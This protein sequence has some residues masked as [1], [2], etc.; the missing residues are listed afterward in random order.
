VS[1]W[2]PIFG[3]ID[4][5]DITT[6]AFLAWLLVRYLRRTRARAA[7]VGLVLLGTI[8]AAARGLDLRLTASLLQGFFAVAVL[9]LVVVFQEDIRRLFEQ[10]GSWRQALKEPAKQS[11]DDDLLVR[12][13]SR[14]AQQHVGALIVLP[15]REPLTRHV[16]GGVPLHGRIS[17]PLLLSI[18]DASSPG[19]DGAVIVRD[20]QVERFSVHLP[21]S[22]NHAALGP[23]GTR[24]AAALGLAERCDALCIVV[25][26]ERGSVSVARDGTLRTLRRPEDLAGELRIDEPDAAPSRPWWRTALAAEAAV[27]VVGALALWMIVVPGSDLIEASV[28]AQ[29]E[30]SN[31]PA[32]YELE[33][34]DPPQVDVL[35]RGLRRDVALAQRAGPRFQVDGYLATLGRRTFELSAGEFEALDGVT[36][37]EIAPES[38]RISLR[39]PTPAAR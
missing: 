30:F 10:L 17:E 14:L 13:C 35:L 21:L 16:E 24:H 1:E 23:V 32:G 2:L 34:V 39:P 31:L 3:W 29:I 4:L 27:S 37:I 5:L 22:A 7:L 15:G 18:F 8:Y 19:H 38:V 11:T 12:V 25:S 6:V 20:G 33:S 36:L 26:E 28:P 9:I